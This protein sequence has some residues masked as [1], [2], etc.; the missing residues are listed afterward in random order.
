[1]EA[2]NAGDKQ[3]LSG[4]S[5]KG[6]VT[7]F[8]E[9]KVI[10]GRSYF[11]SNPSRKSILGIESGGRGRKFSS[12]W[13][14]EQRWVRGLKRKRR[15]APAFENTPPKLRRQEGIYR[16]VSISMGSTG[17]AKTAG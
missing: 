7:P 15:C 5:K 17:R 10:G 14:E 11:S 8:G 13:A 16:V 6:A 1:M 9:E 3:G 12:Y 4:R 2:A